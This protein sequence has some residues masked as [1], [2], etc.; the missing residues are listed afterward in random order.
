MF[1][2]RN[3]NK[4]YDKYVKTLRKWTCTNCIRAKSSVEPKT[5]AYSHTILSPKTDFP[6]RSNNA[7]KEEIVKVF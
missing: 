1:I 5:K 2:T 3:T 4:L 7:K 6:A